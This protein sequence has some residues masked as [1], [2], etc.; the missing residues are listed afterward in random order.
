MTGSILPNG[1]PLI[2]AD[3]STNHIAFS[4]ANLVQQTILTETK[5]HGTTA[6]TTQQKVRVW[7]QV[8]ISI[9]MLGVGILVILAPN[10]F[11]PHQVD[12]SVKRLAAG[13]I[14]AVIGYW[15]S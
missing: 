8:V 12:E 11:V 1:L 15:L 2:L 5:D 7:M 13:W 14:G 3:V 10:F 6:V 9:L 4:G